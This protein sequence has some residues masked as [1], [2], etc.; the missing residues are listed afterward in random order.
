MLKPTDEQAAVATACAA[1]E[2][3]IVEAG[4]GT[5]K[6]TT[7]EHAAFAMLRAN[8]G[9]RGLYVGFNKSTAVEARDRFPG[10]FDCRTG[11]S[12]AYA[13]FGKPLSHKLPSARPAQAPWEVARMLGIQDLVLDVEGAPA[14][15]VVPA[16][17]IA[18]AARDTVDRYCRSADVDLT[19]RHV[20]RDPLPPTVD[21]AQYEEAV[22][23]AACA[24][25]VDL[26]EPEGLLRMPHDVYRKLWAL[27]EPDLRVD[28]LMLDEA[29]DTAPVLAKVLRAQACQQIAVGDSSQQ[30][31]GWAGAIDA[32]ANWGQARRLFLRQSWRFGEVIAEQANLWLDLLPTQLRLIGNPA[33]DSE[34]TTLNGRARAVL[35]RTNVGAVGEVMLALEA[36]K[37]VALAGGGKEIESLARAAGALQA[38]RRTNH[39]ELS[40]FSSWEEVRQVAA[41]EDGDGGLKVLV[42]MIETYGADAVCA[43]MRALEP[44][45]KRAECVVSTGHKAKGLEW[46][47]V[48]A[49]NDFAPR[50]QDQDA[51]GMPMVKAEDAMLSYVTVTRAKVLLDRG[52]LAYVDRLAAAPTLTGAQ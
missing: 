12:L 9:I 24:M 19:R 48:R 44:N 1:G 27:S 23:F 8:A 11:H 6:T 33:I 32:M 20:S 47:S 46:E 43:T 37:R 30:L 18:S 21:R 26:R 51:A 41:A 2:N 10:A 4:A 25:W 35:C 17:K 34:L 3:L 49:A 5:G 15:A 29:Q 13:R 42:R 36:G 38:G 14:P 28:V 40:A 50:E 45:L 7:L 16:V 52:P 39:P 22:L 31:Y